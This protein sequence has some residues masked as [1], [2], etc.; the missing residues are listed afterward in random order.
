MRTL[1]VVAAWIGFFATSGFCNGAAALMPADVLTWR[2]CV[3]MA[4]H[5]NPDLLSAMQAIASSQAQYRGSF[6][7][8]LPSLSLDNSYSRSGSSQ[9]GVLLRNGTTGTVTSHSTLWQLSGG[10]SLDLINV[11]SWAAIQEAA[12]ALHQ[13]Q[14][15]AQV[16]ATTILMN[17]YKTFAALLYAQEEVRVDTAIRDTWKSNAQ[18][19]ALRYDSGAES[20]GDMMNTDANLLQAEASLAQAGRDVAVARQQLSQQLGK[21]QFETLVVTGTWTAPAAP[22]PMPDFDAYLARQPQI[23]VQEAAVEQTRAVITSARSALFPTLS[24]N[25]NKGLE[26]AAELPSDPFWTFSGVLSYPLFG[27]GLTSTYYATRAAERTYEKS[28]QDLRSLRNGLR[29]ALVS[30][31]SAYAQAEDNVHVQKA[32]MEASDQRKGEADINYQS[33][34]MTFENWV[35]IVEDYVSAQVN[36]LRAEQTLIDAEAQWHYAAGEQLGE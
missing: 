8:I 36:F 13:T 22:N 17:L 20:K 4:L 5:N 3:Q 7:G 1:S 27:K 30:A 31:W 28:R 29:S 19:V 33:G 6:N 26:G 21:D 23:E 9:S 18:M 12:G 34:L 32:F 2:D 16:T 35:L 25:Y 24:I 10:V 14:A 11:G 15:G